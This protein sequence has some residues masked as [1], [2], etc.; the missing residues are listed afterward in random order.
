MILTSSGISS[1]N[2]YRY[3]TDGDGLDDG[4]EGALM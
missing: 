4:Y 3:V 2:L 1:Q